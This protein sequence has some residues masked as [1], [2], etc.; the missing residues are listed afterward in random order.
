MNKSAVKRVT[1][2]MN[3]EG[4]LK[5]VTGKFTSVTKITKGKGVIEAVTNMLQGAFKSIKNG[6]NKL[7][8]RFLKGRNLV[9]SFSDKLDDLFL[10]ILKKFT[11]A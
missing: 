11:T 1:N 8:N 4:V 7:V 5:T 2:K 6:V 10:N 9:K 3:G